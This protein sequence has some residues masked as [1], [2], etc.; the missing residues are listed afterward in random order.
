MKTEDEVLA[1]TLE[2]GLVPPK[3]LSARI[4]L[5]LDLVR[6]KHY[7]VNGGPPTVTQVRLLLQELEE[8]REQLEVTQAGLDEAL[9]TANDLLLSARTGF[10]PSVG[11]EERAKAILERLRSLVPDT[12]KEE[13]L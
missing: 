2:V 13:G 6:L 8:V 7:L 1:N 3:G 4:A 12:E 5:P 11:L 10:D 9:D